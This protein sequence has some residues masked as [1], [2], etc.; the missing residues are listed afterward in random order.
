MNNRFS[1]LELD[2]YPEVPDPEVQSKTVQ[3]LL[4][5]ALSA[6]DTEILALQTR[7]SAL[8]GRREHLLAAIGMPEKPKAE[9]KS[10][11][12]RRTKLEDLEGICPEEVESFEAAASRLDEYEKKRGAKYPQD[13]IIEV[14]LA[15]KTLRDQGATQAALSARLG[16]GTQTLTNWVEKFA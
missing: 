13:V 5:E 1:N 14:A 10:K 12:R 6:V 3:S 4:T 15:A 7:I 8:Q 16:V 9:T 2:D 11:T